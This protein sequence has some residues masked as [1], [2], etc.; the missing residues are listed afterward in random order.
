MQLVW[1]SALLPEQFALVSFLLFTPKQSRPG[2]HA[3]KFEGKGRSGLKRWSSGLVD[4]PDDEVAALGFSQERLQLH[5][6]FLRLAPLSILITWRCRT[7]LVPHS[8]IIRAWAYL[9][10]SY[11]TH[12]SWSRCSLLLRS[13]PTQTWFLPESRHLSLCL[14]LPL[15][16][17]T[18]MGVRDLRAHRH[19]L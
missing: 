2:L 9:D 18:Q 11:T 17:R 13:S 5:G 3:S 8:T 14:L 15:L 19:K 7:R 4:L 16:H 1:I 6:G 10:S 12:P